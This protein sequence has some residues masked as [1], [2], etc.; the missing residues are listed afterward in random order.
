MDHSYILDFWKHKF[1]Q[2][3]LAMTVR[4]IFYISLN[5]YLLVNTLEDA[6]VH[7]ELLPMP[8]P[9]L[10]H[11]SPEYP[12]SKIRSVSINFSCKTFLTRN[13]LWC[14]S[15]DFSIWPFR[16]CRGK[17]V[18]RLYHQIGNPAENLK[19]EKLNTFSPQR[20]CPHAVLKNLAFLLKR[21]ILQRNLYVILWARQHE[22]LYKIS[23]ILQECK[24]M[25]YVV[26]LA[27]SRTIKHFKQFLEQSNIA[28][29]LW[30][31]HENFQNFQ[32]RMSLWPPVTFTLQ[33]SLTW[34]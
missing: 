17:S 5:E 11:G 7:W 6:R 13:N 33:K 8:S 16:P 22:W 27:V 32:K 34:W 23:V 15:H 20:T 31:K 28:H 10:F 14:S 19:R 12:I 1:W 25:G 9:K 30:G 26:L 18:D 21:G 4:I 2:N 3:I 24:K 29:D